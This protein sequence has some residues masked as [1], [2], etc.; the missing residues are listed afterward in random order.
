MRVAHKRDL[1]LL[2]RQGHKFDLVIGIHVSDRLLDH[3]TFLFTFLLHESRLK[4]RFHEDSRTP[5]SYG[6]L[7]R[8]QL[9]ADVV[10]LQSRERGQYVFARADLHA[11]DSD[12]RS[13][14]DTDHVFDIRRNL[15]S[16]RKIRPD[17]PHAGV[18]RSRF[19]P[20]LRLR[21]GMESPPSAGNLLSYRSLPPEHQS[22]HSE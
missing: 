2:G 1:E 17:E 7:I 10:D 12:I 11:V 16:S 6:R 8:R 3:H 22:P 9:H 4:Q 15:R 13:P 19:E 18:H 5:V 21:P 14:E 20:D